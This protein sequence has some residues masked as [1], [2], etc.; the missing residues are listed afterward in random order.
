MSVKIRFD[1][2]VW[3][4]AGIRDLDES[5]ELGPFDWIEIET[6]VM[7]AAADEGAVRHDPLAVLHT[8]EGNWHWTIEDREG[9]WH[10]FVIYEAE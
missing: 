1:R 2:F 8:E 4:D 9:I 6:N 3:N 7:C 10:Y 5:L